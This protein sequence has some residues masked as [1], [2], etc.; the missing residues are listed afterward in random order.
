MLKIAICDDDVVLTSKLEELLEKISLK[1]GIKA[2]IDI[3]FDGYGILNAIKRGEYYDIIYMDIEMKT[4]DGIEAAKEIRKLNTKVLIMY[5][6][7]H[8]QYLKQLF[9]VEPFRFISKPIEEDLFEHDFLKAYNKI[10]K[11]DVYFNY[12]FN[13]SD[14]KVL[15]SDIMYFESDGRIINIIMTNSTD[16]FYDKLNDVEDRLKKSKFTFLRIHQSY[17]V[18]F[19]YIEKISFS[20]ITL[21]DGTELQISEE[22]QKQIRK[23]YGQLLGGELVDF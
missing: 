5:I 20:K 9:E 18:N 10:L 21:M 13:K 19:K 7:S 16:K 17:L 14:I 12:K 15:I 4:L 8:E 23:E 1:N 6:S 22:R 2:D 11:E 3:Y